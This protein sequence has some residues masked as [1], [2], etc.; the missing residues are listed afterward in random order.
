MERNGEE[1]QSSS[2]PCGTGRRLW[3]SRAGQEGEGERRKGGRHE[4][5]ERGVTRGTVRENNEE[6]GGGSSGEKS[7]GGDSAERAR[8]KEHTVVMCKWRGVVRDSR[9]GCHGDSGG[10]AAGRDQ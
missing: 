5:G 8:E 3:S 6:V 4:G 1:G 10:G 7:W 2:T 9:R